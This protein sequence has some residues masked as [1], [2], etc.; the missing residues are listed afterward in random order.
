MKKCNLFFLMLLASMLLASCGGG[1]TSLTGK[2]MLGNIPQYLVQYVDMSKQC[3]DEQ[4]FEDNDSKRDEIIKKY[5]EKWEKYVA[6]SKLSDMISEGLKREIPVDASE[7]YGLSSAHFE[8]KDFNIRIGENK[9]YPK[10]ELQMKY[11]GKKPSNSYCAFLDEKDSV[12]FMGAIFS[13]YRN[14]SHIN[15]TFVIQN[16]KISE[17]R[18]A[19]KFASYSLDKAVKIKVPT[20][21]EIPELLKSYDRNSEALMKSLH[22][23]GVL[24]LE[25]YEDFINMTKKAEAEE[26]QEEEEVDK[27]KPGLVD[28]AYFGLR[29]PVS[30]FTEY[31][32]GTRVHAYRFSEK[33]KWEA[34]DNKALSIFLTDVKR[35]SEKRI[36]GY[37]IE[38]NY[39]IYDYTITYDAKTGWVSKIACEG[40]DGDKVTTFSYDENGN[41]TKDVEDGSYIE[42]GADEAIKE[43]IV[44]NYKYESFDKYGNWTKR[45]IK[46][47]DS[48]TW[49]E[50]RDINYYNK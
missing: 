21:D 46:R 6:D 33:G 15:L 38:E 8:A 4:E 30:S 43:H 44:T 23:A 35:D 13:D 31:C 49:V 24:E 40:S 48:G 17:M 14:N 2:G 7:E 11:S 32:D 36:V 27:S 50:K 26:K 34:R 47:S 29:G 45:T 20:R 25:A 28:L 39:C 16:L 37:Q 12:V 41:V 22:E 5:Q 42:E 10:I 9:T 3:I 18:D 19:L 1:E